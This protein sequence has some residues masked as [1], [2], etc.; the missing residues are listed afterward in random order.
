MGCCVSLKR[1]EDKRKMQQ[2][3]QPVKSLAMPGLP[4]QSG[5]PGKR[6]LWHQPQDREWLLLPEQGGLFSKKFTRWRLWEEKISSRN[7]QGSK[8]TMAGFSFGHSKRNSRRKKLKQKLK[9]K[10]KTQIFG[11]LQKKK[12]FFNCKNWPIFSYKHTNSRVN[13]FN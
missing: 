1:K 5:Q 12:G 6:R 4:Q 11:I 2:H 3:L 13:L 9:L 8:T 10:P 7:R